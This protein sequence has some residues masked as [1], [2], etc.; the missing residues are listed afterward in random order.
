VLSRDVP[1]PRIENEG[2]GLKFQISR[3]R[4]LTFENRGSGSKE[5]KTRGSGSGS[6]VKNSKF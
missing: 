2:P 4:V 6:N 1:G 3:V 5:L